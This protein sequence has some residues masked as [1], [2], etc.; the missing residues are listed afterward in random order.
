MVG[1]LIVNEVTKINELKKIEYVLEHVPSSL[2]G[3]LLPTKYKIF[4]QQVF[5]DDADA[6]FKTKAEKH[7][8]K[9]KLSK[10]VSNRKNRKI[11]ETESEYCIEYTGE[12][13][14]NKSVDDMFKALEEFVKSTIDDVN[15]YI[16]DLRKP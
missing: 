15:N 14:F 5:S 6:N 16:D 12:Y 3:A 9:T 4:F 8:E 1:L 11:P 2:N 10:T 13:S 7:L